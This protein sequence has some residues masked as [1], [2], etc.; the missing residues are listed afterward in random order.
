MTL[1]LFAMIIGWV[2]ALAMISLIA[3]GKNYAKQEA[4]KKLKK[5]IGYKEEPL[6]KDLDVKIYDAFI[7]K[8]PEIVARKIG[9]NAEEYYKNC[10]L[11]RKPANLKGLIAKI[12]LSAMTVLWFA[13]IGLITKNWYVSIAGILIGLF[14]IVYLVKRPEEQA[15]DVRAQIVAEMP[16]FLD[17]L[18]TALYINMPVEEAISIT[19]KHLKGTLLADEFAKTVAEIQLG[20]FG[21]QTALENMSHKYEVD[22]FSDFVLDI[23]TAYD[24]GIPIYDVVARKNKEIKQTNLLT[25]KENASKLNSTIVIPIAIFKLLPLIVILCIPIIYQLRDTGVF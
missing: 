19:A 13:V 24:K 22:I 14:L 15:A 16:R 6:Y 18:Q 20:A 7:H 5:E 9:I 11:I 1:A 25:L 4:D 2:L 8:K 23:V 17:M 21:W 10:E 12:G 3:I